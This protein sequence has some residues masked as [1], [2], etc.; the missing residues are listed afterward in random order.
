MAGDGEDGHMYVLF[1]FIT[2]FM[3]LAFI[4]RRGRFH[5]RLRLLTIRSKMRRTDACSSV[6]EFRK[7]KIACVLERPQ[8]WFEH[9][10]LSH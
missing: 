8:F 3:Q 7:R 9:I 2:V 5:Q 1:L 10:V 4:R 6:T